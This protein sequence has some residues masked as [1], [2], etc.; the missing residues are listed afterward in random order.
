MKYQ[1]INSKTIDKWVEQGWQ[2]G[3]PI[4]HETYVNAKNGNWDVVLTPT[5]CTKNGLVN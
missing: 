3:Q 1:D 2:R 4:D 5:K